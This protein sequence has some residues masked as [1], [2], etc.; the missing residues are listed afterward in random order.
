RLEAACEQVHTVIHLA[1]GLLSP[2]PERI[3]ADA[4][5]VAN[6]AGSAGVH[7]LV[8]LSVLG[9]SPHAQ[10]DLRRAMAAAEQLVAECPV[11]SVA[12]RVPVVLDDELREVLVGTP[13]PEH[14]RTS[15]VAVIG[16]AAAVDVLAALDDVR[17]ESTS[18]HAAMV[19]NVDVFM[20]VSSLAEAIVGPDSSTGGNIA[21]GV[22]RPLEQ[23]PLL[24]PG[25]LGPWHDD[26]EVASDAWAFTGI[27]PAG[28]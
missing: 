6:A 28:V 23:V 8:L 19:A 9:A 4:A 16:V 27:D 21:R 17:S 15:K 22:Y 24:A 20:P 10:D 14:V 7:R 11:P 3:V 18:G 25:L 2:S 1:G 5:S 26:D 13:L 12:L